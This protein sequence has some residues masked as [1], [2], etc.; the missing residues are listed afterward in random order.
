M[1]VTREV[2]CSS[3]REEG[4]GDARTKLSLVNREIRSWVNLDPGA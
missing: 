1:P 2:A 3:T 4:R